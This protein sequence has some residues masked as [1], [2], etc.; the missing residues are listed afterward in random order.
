MVVAGERDPLL[1][2]TRH[3]VTVVPGAGH[4]VHIPTPTRWPGPSRTSC[5]HDH[6]GA[7]DQRT[8]AGIDALS[9]PRGDRSQAPC[10]LGHAPHRGQRGAG[11]V[12]DLPARA[13]SPPPGAAAGSQ[14]GSMN[15][16]S[17]SSLTTWPISGSAGP[18]ESPKSLRRSSPR[19]LETGVARAVEVVGDSAELDVEG[20]RPGHVADG[21]VAVE[22]PVL[23]RAADP[24]GPEG[25]RRLPFDVEEVAAADAGRPGRRCR[26]RSKPGRSRR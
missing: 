12:V 1:T 5:G 20:H 2:A 11:P 14:A 13:R 4:D 21:E 16:R 25:H 24:G 18:K 6:V 10:H 7:P 19:R 3:P 22:G 26:C 17:S 9:A 15:S 8:S 23:A